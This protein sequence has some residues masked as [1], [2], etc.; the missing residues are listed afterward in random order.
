M[1]KR[2]YALEALLLRTE[3]KRTSVH[4]FTQLCDK[5]LFHMEST[6]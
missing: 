5:M 2:F 3:E 4:E 6:D 1:I